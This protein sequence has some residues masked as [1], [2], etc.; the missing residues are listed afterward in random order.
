M[1]WCRISSTYSRISRS[2]GMYR[3]GVLTW[4]TLNPRANS[5]IRTVNRSVDVQALHQISR[6]RDAPA[7]EN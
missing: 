6:L 1:S 3:P 4:A 5:R 2:A 7:E